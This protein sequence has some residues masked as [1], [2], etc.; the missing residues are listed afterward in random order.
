MS[1]SLDY[2]FAKFESDLIGETSVFL[3]TGPILL[4]LKEGGMEAA[5]ETLIKVGSLIF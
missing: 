2:L 4:V 5:A 1:F 3:L